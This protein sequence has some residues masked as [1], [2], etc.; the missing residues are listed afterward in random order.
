MNTPRHGTRS[1]FSLVEV[2]IALGLVSFV[3]IALLGLIS[4]GMKSSRQAEE[5]TRIVGIGASTL[6]WLRHVD[7][8]PVG[9]T[10]LF[11]DTD[12]NETTNSVEAFY[13]CA[14]SFR[15]PSTSEMP[16]VGTNVYLV[17]LSFSWPA[18]LA[19]PTRPRSAIM[20]S[21]LFLP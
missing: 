20:H 9:G 14:V 2:V 17:T 10:N 5:D 16:G 8:L 12:G 19:A 11:F 1:A 7:P 21:A 4:I 6:A 15:V 3:V 13:D 18:H